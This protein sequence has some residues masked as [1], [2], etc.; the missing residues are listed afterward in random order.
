MTLKRI[1]Q[2]AYHFIERI[3]RESKVF[4]GRLKV[5]GWKVAYETFID[6]LVPPGKKERYIT[7]IS[8]YIDNYLDDLIEDYKS[9]T[10]NITNETKYGFEKVPVWCCWWQ[11]EK[12]MPELVHMCHTRLK[13]VIPKEKA[14]LHLI[15][16]ENY[17]SYVTIP[18]YIIEKF[19]NGIITMTTMSDILRFYL[20]YK[21][22]GYWVDSTVFFTDH[23]PEEYFTKDFFCQRMADPIKCQREAC[24]GNWCGF[25]MAGQK[26]SIIFKY[27]IDAFSKWWKDYNM[28]IDYVLI[29]YLL[30]TGFR[31]IPSINRI[32]N[33][34]PNNNED[35]FE[36][37]QVLNQ[38][39]SDELYE[40]LTKRNVMHKLTYKM[41]LEKR[42][43]EGKLTLYGYLLEQVYKAYG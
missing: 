28:I 12:S 6:G 5:F 38:P 40:R 34:V 16:L 24:K 4:P 41:D 10:E 33:T 36:M 18:D 39:Y 1:L 3:I 2:R 26:G 7:T 25:S 14:E 32:I 15:T 17:Q 13:Q 22:G 42:T 8:S 43:K 9:I 29:D 23:I 21:Y 11:G 27:M 19:N 37:Y 30:W 20:L 31:K 35:I